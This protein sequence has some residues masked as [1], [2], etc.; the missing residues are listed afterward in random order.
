MGAFQSQSDS[1]LTQKALEDLLGRLHSD[2]SQAGEEYLRLHDKLVSYFEFEKCAGPEDLADEV[3][4]RVA[5]KLNQ[6]ERIDR[7]GAY[8]LGVAR[9][10]ALETRREEIDAKRKFRQIARVSEENGPSEK[11]LCLSCLDHCLTKLPV[12][13]RSII[14][15]YYSGDRRARI[16]N[17]KSLA[18]DLGL[19]AAALRNRALRVRGNLET[20]MKRCFRSRRE[21]PVV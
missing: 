6:G 16:D 19:E 10:V 5:R 12:E 14:L 9:L 11:E 2:P 17:R 3:L 8:C 1:R 18:A 4:D 7:V 20:C 21:R 13:S 15:G